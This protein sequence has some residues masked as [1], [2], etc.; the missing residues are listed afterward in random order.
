MV[1]MLLDVIATAYKY[2]N[3]FT[4]RTIVSYASEALQP[5]IGLIFDLISL[6]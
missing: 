5:C 4:T 1:A 3:S 2:Q 6:L